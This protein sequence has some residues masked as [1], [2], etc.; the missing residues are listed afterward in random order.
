MKERPLTWTANDL[1]DTQY[2]V[3]S[4]RRIHGGKL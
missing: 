3:S 2:A 4:Y 1:N